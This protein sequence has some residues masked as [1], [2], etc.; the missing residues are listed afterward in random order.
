MYMDPLRL[1]LFGQGIPVEY[2]LD[3]FNTPHTGTTLFHPQNWLCRWRCLI[4]LRHLATTSPQGNIF[5]RHIVTCPLTYTSNYSLA[6]VKQHPVMN[7]SDESP[8]YD[9]NLSSPIKKRDKF[10]INYCNRT[11]LSQ[12]TL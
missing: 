10:E 8:F 12:T 1:F 9:L 2:E 3:K 7:G 5:W 11:F 4:P 6:L